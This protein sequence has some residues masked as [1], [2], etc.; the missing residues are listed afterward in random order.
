M[1]NTSHSYLAIVLG[2]TDR[3]VFG[4]EPPHGL[5]HLEAIERE[6]IA[7]D[8]VDGARVLRVT[9]DVTVSERFIPLQSLGRQDALDV[10]QLANH[11]LRGEQQSVEC[12]VAVSE[13]EQW[14]LRSQQIESSS[15][16]LG[17]GK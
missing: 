11:W 15:K 12:L 9:L 5:V 8:N 3:A 1:S 7:I 17:A 13:H 14:V 10:R 2:A 6:H 16:V 4:E